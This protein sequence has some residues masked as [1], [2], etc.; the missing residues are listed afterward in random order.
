MTTVLLCDWFLL[1]K[2][3]LSDLVDA[4][5]FSAFAALFRDDNDSS[6]VFIVDSE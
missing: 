2:P 3:A 5:I 1:C 6:C 4:G